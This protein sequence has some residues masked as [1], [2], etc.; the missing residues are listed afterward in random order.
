M[1][2]H[3]NGQMKFIYE[4]SMVETSLYVVFIGRIE[5]EN[6]TAA[7]MF[8]FYRKQYNDLVNLYCQ[9]RTNRPHETYPKIAAAI[10]RTSRLLECWH[11]VALNIAKR[12]FFSG[13]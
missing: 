5:M 6:K 7:E 9:V 8:A 2:A 3:R 11:N 12:K 1:T 10:W 13:G 4:Q